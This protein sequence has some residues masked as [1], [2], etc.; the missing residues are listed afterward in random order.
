M[1]L[2]SDYRPDSHPKSRR[3]DIDLLRFVAVTAVVLFH[4]EAPGFSGGFLGV[5]MFFVISGYLITSHIRSEIR[6]ERFK[7]SSFFL[8]RIRRLYPAL[9]FTLF[10]TAVV[11]L[12]V[13][14]PNLISDFALSLIFSS[15]YLSNIHFWSGADYFDF[16]SIYKPLLHT[17]SLSVEEQFYLIWPLFLMLI[18]LRL[19]ARAI[20]L[21]G[22]LSL[23]LGL[24]PAFSSSTTF[25]QFP[26]RIYEF[27]IGALLTSAALSSRLVHYRAFVLPVS[28]LLVGVSLFFSSEL[29]PNPSWGTLAVCLG[30]AGIISASH[31]LLQ[32]DTIITAPM[33]RI[34]LIS[35]SIY[36]AHWPLVVVYKTYFPGDISAIGI[37]ALILATV[38]IAE[39]MYRCIEQPASRIS[40]ETGSKALVGMVAGLFIFGLAFQFTHQRIYSTIHH[41]R[42][43]V[44]E[45]LDKIP[46]RRDV[47]QIAESE[48]SQIS[49]PDYNGEKKNILILGD[50]HA[51]D[52]FAALRY[53]LS[54]KKYNLT[55]LSGNSACDPLSSGSINISLDALYENHTNPEATAQKCLDF[56]QSFLDHVTAQ[57][58]DFIVFSEAWRKV[59]LEFLQATIEE[60]QSVTNAEIVV[61]GRVPQWVGTPETVFRDFSSVEQLNDSAWSL[62]H[63]YFDGIDE[64]LQE[65][66]QETGVTFVLKR[67]VVC[68][69]F[70]CAV[71]VGNDLLYS[72]SQHFSPAGMKYYGE[73]LRDHPSMRSIIEP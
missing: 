43:L 2:F 20:V 12:F 38:I 59:S 1:Q 49:W 40:L 64:R 23:G 32:K 33:L 39:F 27:S 62:R 58:P 18:S 11:V 7:L 54:P 4:F 47:V 10:A 68:P 29:D 44:A 42:G 48:I 69:N 53:S 37:L 25:F 70:K 9:L 34:G 3:C 55:L 28:F 19:H 14:P 72:D 50:S 15:V 51:Y 60:L 56:H 63:P 6:N 66:A 45:I 24:V 31:P 71:I 61:L 41:N 46:A 21:V 30:T 57:K 73:R 5:D 22:L 26:F 16:E 67:E 35:Y 36:L 8:K 13:F 52:V 17:W 65:I